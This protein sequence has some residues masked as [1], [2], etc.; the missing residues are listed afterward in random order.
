MKDFFRELWKPILL[1]SIV[2]FFMIIGSTMD[3]EK[4]LNIL[5]NFINSFSNNNFIIYSI[6]FIIAIIMAVP[7]SILFVL[8]SINFGSFYGFFINSFSST[9]GACFAFLISR[10]FAQ[11]SIKN[12]LSKKPNYNKIYEL[13]ASKGT[14]FI[15]ITRLI[16]IFPFNLMNYIFGLTKVDFYK[17]AFWTWITMMPNILLYTL[18]AD[19]IKGFLTGKTLSIIGFIVIIG[20]IFLLHF[21]TQKIKDNI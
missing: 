20:S 3:V 12:F 21:V 2:L 7:G 18:A 15:A 6:I 13:T 4:Y 10:Y 8:T 5:L 16:P 1:I 19:I 17:Y 11:D 14:T 9:L